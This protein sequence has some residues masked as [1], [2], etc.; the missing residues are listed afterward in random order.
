M[1][2]E[3]IPLYL[4]NFQLDS[5][6]ENAPL[7]PQSFTALLEAILKYPQIRYLDWLEKDEA[8][9]DKQVYEGFL[10][11]DDEA[12]QKISE[13]G[14]C[15]ALKE[16]VLAFEALDDSQREMKAFIKSALS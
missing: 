4:D 9:E 13:P 8:Q 14:F 2:C 16:Q 15:N 11:A 1:N 6:V 12:M 3:E 5:F 10:Q 7:R